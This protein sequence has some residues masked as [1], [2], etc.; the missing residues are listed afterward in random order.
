MLKRLLTP[1]KEPEGDPEKRLPPFPTSPDQPSFAWLRR[2]LDLGPPAP[3]YLAVRAAR[4]AVA[5]KPDDPQPYLLLAQTYETLLYQTREGDR[6]LMV[7]YPPG[8]VPF[9]LLLR[10]VQIKAA[11]H[12]AL[13]LDPDDAMALD[14]AQDLYRRTG[15]LDLALTYQQHELEVLG[16]SGKDVAE[17]GKNVD[18]AKEQM[19]KKQNLYLLKSA[20]KRVA[21]KVQSALQMGLGQTALD[22]L[23][24]VEWNVPDDK[25]PTRPFLVLQY[26]TLLMQTG[27]VDDVARELKEDEERLRKSLGFDGTVGMPAYDWLRVE[28]AAARGDYADADRWLNVMETTMRGDVSQ[29][30]L[31]LTLQLAGSRFLRGASAAGAAG[32]APVSPADNVRDSAVLFQIDEQI[33]EGLG[34]A[35]DLEA[36]RGWLA[37][38]SGDVNAARARID[39]ALN[40]PRTAE[41]AAQDKALDLPA[42]DQMYFRARPL[43]ELCREWLDKGK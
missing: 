40:P 14:L 41:E 30:R 28:S 24:K 20:N 26:L 38:E 35:A 19:Q 3:L 7:A 4:R 27:Q 15:F 16:Q 11:L 34:R 17:L 21:E 32:W 10:Q 42:P 5:A 39:A 23:Q 37:L 25:D 6:T 33:P 9:P 12:R 18:A 13:D 1:E 31:G 22:E 2:Q 8:Y 29:L 36:V 43:A